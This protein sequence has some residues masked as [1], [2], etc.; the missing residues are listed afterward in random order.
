MTKGTDHGGTA[1]PDRQPLP[2]AWM[3][4]EAKRRRAWR[5]LDD[6]EY[7]A[8]F[9]DLC[10]MYHPAVAAVMAHQAAFGPGASKRRGACIKP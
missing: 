4:V 1:Q 3:R 9:E 5:E 8:R 10:V 6:A 2:I 7:Q